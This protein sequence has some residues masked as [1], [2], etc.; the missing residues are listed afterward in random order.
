MMK[1]NSKKS[2]FILLHGLILINSLGGVCSKMAGRYPVGSFRFLLYYGFLML[3]LATYALGWQQV[4]KHMPLTTAYL[5]KASGMVWA[6][7]WGTVLFHEQLTVRM[8]IG[9]ITV[10]AGIMLVVRS[11]G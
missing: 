6:V 9:L 5:S 3:I 4:I 8:I 10:L 7:L 1:E 2:S 11:D